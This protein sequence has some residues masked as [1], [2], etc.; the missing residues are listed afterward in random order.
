MTSCAVRLKFPTVRLGE[1]FFF[2]FTE[3]FAVKL[4]FGVDEV[5]VDGFRLPCRRFVLG[6]ALPSTRI[7]EI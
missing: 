7:I 1:A 6:A 5:G 4:A 3:V 2:L